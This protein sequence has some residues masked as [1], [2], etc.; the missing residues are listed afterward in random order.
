MKSELIED[1]AKG[2]VRVSRR[3]ALTLLGGGAV[4]FSKPLHAAPAFAGSAMA[5]DRKTGALYRAREQRLWRSADDGRSWDQVP[6]PSLPLG[7]GIASLSVSAGGA[8]YLAGPRLGVMRRADPGGRWEAAARG[9]PSKDVVAVAAHATQADT[10]YAYVAERGIFRSEDAG[11]RWRLMD[12]GPR[13]GLTSFVH[14]DMADSMQTGWLLTAGL[15]GVRLSMD[16]FCGWRST[17]ELPGPA[18]A[19]SYDPQN[20]TRVVASTR[21]GVYESLDAGQAWA[22]LSGPGTRVDALAFA[23]DS[24]VYAVAGDAVLR[25]TSVGWERIDA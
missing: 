8:L 11:Q 20:P 1:P 13:G 2:P 15:Q 4:I 21:E 7:A 23:R 14:S 25:R 3:R 5:A 6:T 22:R 10:V 12:A 9:L 24:T 16:C 19:I 17:G 18:K